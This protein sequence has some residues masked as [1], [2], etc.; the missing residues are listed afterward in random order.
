M[1]NKNI[2]GDI[3]AVMN[4]KKLTKFEYIRLIAL[5]IVILVIISTFAYMSLSFI[6]MSRS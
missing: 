5:A 4:G 3:E 6:L 2:V 1:L